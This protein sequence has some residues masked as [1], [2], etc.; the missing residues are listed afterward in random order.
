MVKLTRIPLVRISPCDL[1]R[2][3]GGGVEVGKVHFVDVGFYATK[4]EFCCN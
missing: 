1:K 2:R 3:W 4:L